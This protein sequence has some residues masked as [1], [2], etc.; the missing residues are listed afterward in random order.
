MTLFCSDEIQ[1]L[2]S[3]FLDDNKSP[4]V[5]S[6]LLSI[7]ADLSRALVWTVS[8]LPQISSSPNL[9]SNTFEMISN[10]C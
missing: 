9:S 5:S 10:N 8:I 1:F 6:A 4:Q 2:S 7:A 3:S